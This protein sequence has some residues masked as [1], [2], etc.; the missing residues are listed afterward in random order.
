MLRNHGFGFSNPSNSETCTFE[1]EC[2]ILYKRLFQTLRPCVI[3]KHIII[4]HSMYITV[5]KYEYNIQYHITL[6]IIV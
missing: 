4:L 5:K 6:H 3:K 1:F 2:N